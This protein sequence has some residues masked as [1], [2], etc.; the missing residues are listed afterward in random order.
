MVVWPERRHYAPLDAAVMT[1]V[2]A[3]D[4][5]GT[6][7]EYRSGEMSRRYAA[8]Q[9]TFIGRPIPQTLARVKAALALGYEVWIFT[10][11]LSPERGDTTEMAAAI[12][13]WTLEHVGQRL[14]ATAI[15]LQRF[16]EIWD[17]KAVR[18]SKNQGASGF[19]LGTLWHELGKN[20]NATLE[21]TIR[22]PSVVVGDEGSNDR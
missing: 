5:D 2:I 15:K 11:R 20:V 17:D 6:L 18:I 16:D 8:G 14:D 10:A 7:A 13:A 19:T 22:V 3:C 12:A 21:S 9:R 4:L 1:K